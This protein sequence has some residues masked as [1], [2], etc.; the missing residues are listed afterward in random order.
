MQHQVSDFLTW[1]W[2][3]IGLVMRPSTSQ[4]YGKTPPAKFSRIGAMCSI[5]F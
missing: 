2:S 3:M 5:I 4:D 1:Y